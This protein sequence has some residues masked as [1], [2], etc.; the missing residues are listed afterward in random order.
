MLL[1]KPYYVKTPREGTQ[2]QKKTQ[3]SEFGLQHGA[4]V[5]I[6]FPLVFNAFF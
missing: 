2:Q 3:V 4:C 5:I 1:E 6:F